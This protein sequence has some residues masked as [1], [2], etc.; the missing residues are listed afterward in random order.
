MAIMASLLNS[1]TSIS[2]VPPLFPPCPCMSLS[3]S[4]SSETKTYEE[5]SAAPADTALE[6]GQ[7]WRLEA[8]GR[9]FGER[10]ANLC[11]ET[12]SWRRHLPCG[13]F[14]SLF[15]CPCVPLLFLPRHHLILS[16]LL[17]WRRFSRTL[18]KR[19]ERER[20]NSLSQPP[21]PLTTTTTTHKAKFS[22]RL[23]GRE[24]RSSSQP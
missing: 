3:L 14:L 24:R 13:T 15:P 20:S 11:C 1:P 5:V 16:N 21:P 4:F 18:Q 8:E 19:R 6:G 22:L 7:S 17:L 23:R 10:E 9:Y 2:N 12:C